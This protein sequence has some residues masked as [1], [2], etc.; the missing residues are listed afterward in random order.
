M[1]KSAASIA[2]HITHLL[3]CLTTLESDHRP[4]SNI[5]CDQEK[6]LIQTSSS[7]IL[8]NIQNLFSQDLDVKDS[9]LLEPDI[10][11]IDHRI[12]TLQEAVSLGNHNLETIKQQAENLMLEIQKVLYL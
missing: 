2:T 4:K 11:D 5:T 10:P 9:K 8:Q 12:Q 7:M 3:N 1:E 6:L